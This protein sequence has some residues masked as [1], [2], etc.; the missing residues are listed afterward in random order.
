MESRESAA[1]SA[2]GAARPLLSNLRSPAAWV[3]SPGLF[4]AATACTVAF[5]AY[6]L[7]QRAILGALNVDEIY[8]SHVL[9]LVGQGKRIYVDFYSNH[10]PTYFLLLKPVVSVLSDSP[11]DLGFV[12]AIRGLSAVILLA[13]LL[14]GWWIH[15]MVPTREPLGYLA[16]WAL[17]LL[18]AVHARSLEIRTDTVGLILMNTAWAV[19][20]S[21]VSRQRLLLA[22]VLAGTA[23]FFSGRAGL[24]ALVAGACLL[25]LAYW[26]RDMRA[27]RQLWVAAGGFLGLLAAL[28]MADP[29]GMKLLVQSTVIDPARYLDAVSFSRRVLPMDRASVLVLIFLALYSGVQM[30]RDGRVERGAVVAGACVGQLLLVV[31]D[32]APYQY[33]YGWATVPVVFG[34][35]SLSRR[36]A[37]LFAGGVALL[38]VPAVFAV[39]STSPFAPPLGTI[40]RSP[41][42]PALSREAVQEIPQPQLVRMMLTGERQKALGNQLRVREEICRRASRGVLAVWSV[43]PICLPDADHHWSGLRWPMFVQSAE[44]ANFAW[45]MDEFVGII[46]TTRPALFVWNYRRD[47]LPKL[48]PALEE[49]LRPCYDLFDGFALLNSHPCLNSKP[50]RTS[51]DPRP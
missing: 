17:I 15:R 48:P 32:P 6:C 41:V 22:A 34:V 2:I 7:V 31:L 18:I 9:W 23:V 39:V 19:A 5:W 11:A 3:R 4:A 24:M 50:E 26:T 44:A 25:F 30:L 45:T 8:F 47:L 1:A 28:Y 27:F 12:W 42:E 49:P 10:L 14:V 20:L 16:V 36:L 51:D 38:Y 43:H 33:D 35:V 21:R 13:Y 46:M 29:A 37:T 40:V